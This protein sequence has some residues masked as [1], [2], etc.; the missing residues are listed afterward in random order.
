MGHLKFLK[1]GV[2]LENQKDRIGS[3]CFSGPFPTPRTTAHS[4]RR[5]TQSWSKACQ[6]PF[7]LPR[8]GSRIQPGQGKDLTNKLS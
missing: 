6:K 2:V 3:R 4:L 8:N 7:T 1:Y 5:N